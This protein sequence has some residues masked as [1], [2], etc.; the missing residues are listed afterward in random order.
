M[1]IL[2]GKEN[3]E[4]MVQ[5][6]ITNK[7][8][9]V[10][11]SKGGESCFVGGVEVETRDTGLFLYSLGVT[12]W[13]ATGVNYLVDIDETLEYEIKTGICYDVRSCHFKPVAE[14]KSS[15]IM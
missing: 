5:N 2:S 6:A 4:Q 14:N 1:K 11:P 7:S 15:A 10:M 8:V 13:E 9:V 12:M 3:L